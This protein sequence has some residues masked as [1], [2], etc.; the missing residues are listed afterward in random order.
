MCASPQREERVSIRE[1]REIGGKLHESKMRLFVAIFP[2]PEVV[3]A[4]QTAISRLSKDLPPKAIRWTAPHQ[5]HLTLNFLGSVEIGRIADF[6][7]VL[8]SASAQFVCH[9]LRATGLGCF[10]NA[11]RAR[12]VWAGLSG[13]LESLQNLKRYLDQS[14]EKLDYVPETRAFHPHLTIGRVAE[15][16]PGQSQLLQREIH[17][18]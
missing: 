11:K 13:D 14:F 3:D 2:S 8:L 9:D 4:L 16:R 15:L 7:T 6:E 18:L 17:A 5:I 1:I 10:P 12:T